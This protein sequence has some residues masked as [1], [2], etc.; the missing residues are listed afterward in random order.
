[1]SNRESKIRRIRVL[2]VLVAVGLVL[3]G[4]TTYPL[5]WEVSLLSQWFGEASA[6]SGFAEVSRFITHI[7][8]GVSLVHHQY[9]VILYGLDWLGFAHIAIALAFVGPIKKP[10]E[11]Y[12]VV[13]WGLWVCL[14]CVPAIFFYGYS[15]GIPLFWSVIDCMFPL[16]AL[17]PL[18]IAYRDILLLK[19]G[20]KS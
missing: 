6:L 10:L 8:E 16:V 13:E 1:M 9:P 11:H 18:S 20:E 12:W 2:L 17:V 19:A 3:V 4:L 14:L 5:L 15:R 7:Y